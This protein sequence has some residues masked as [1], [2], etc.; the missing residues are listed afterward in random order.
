MPADTGFKLQIRLSTTRH[1][2]TLGGAIESESS[3]AEFI[4]KSAENHRRF[5]DTAALFGA[6][7]AVLLYGPFV[8]LSAATAFEISSDAVS[9]DGGTRRY[10]L[11]RI[12]WIKSSPS[13]A[14]DNLRLNL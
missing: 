5:R 8:Y 1:V 3:L 4:D 7:L 14:R 11:P 12:V 10:P 9:V 2:V 13:G 6:D